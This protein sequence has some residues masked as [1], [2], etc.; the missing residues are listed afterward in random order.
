MNKYLWRFH[1]DCGR[2]GDVEGLFVATEEEVE[3]LIGRTVWFGEILGKHSE[4]YGTIEEGDVEKID[5]D[6][7]TVQKVTVIL[8]ETWSGYNPME[9]AYYECSRCNDEMPISEL[10]D[11][12]DERVCWQCMTKEE[13]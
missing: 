11:V 2:N 4:V 3:D 13:R 5:L 12:Q 7:E 1:W 10:W 9:Y 8:G 6:P